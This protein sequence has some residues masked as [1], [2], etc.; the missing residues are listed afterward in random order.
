MKNIKKKDLILGIIFIVLG[1]ILDQI[2]KIIVRA[3]MEVGDSID[4]INNF[5]SITHV[6]NTGAAWG[7][8]SGYTI[9]LLLVSFVILGFFIYMFRN[10]NFKKRMVF[11]I[12]L[13]LVISGTIGNMIDRIV[14][15]SVTDFLDFII[16][17]Y[18]F[19]V[20][21]IADI[22]LVVGF[23][24]FIIDMIFISTDE[25]LKQLEKEESNN[26]LVEENNDSTDTDLIEEEK[27]D[28]D[29]GRNW[30]S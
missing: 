11:S 12:S 25:K 10:I 7:G 5:F 6:E 16:F 15:R 14:F 27:E 23:F 3:K 17:A 13:V 20:F 30:N 26:E 9:L 1:I 18:D 8:F 22:L 2:I 21:N 29:E 24:L 19:P 28:I 4:L